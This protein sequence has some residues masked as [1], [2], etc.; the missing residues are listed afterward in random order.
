MCV[1]NSANSAQF[2]PSN[3]S[4]DYIVCFFFLVFLVCYVI[5]KKTEKVSKA[6]KHGKHEDLP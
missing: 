6:L 1:S 5:K 4:L 3:N 2:V